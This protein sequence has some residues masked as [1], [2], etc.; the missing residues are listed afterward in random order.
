MKAL[1]PSE[2]HIA[3]QP[4]PQPPSQPAPVL[5]AQ[6]IPG[7]RLSDVPARG[8]FGNVPTAGKPQSTVQPAATEVTTGTATPTTKQHRQG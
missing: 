8:T 4:A 6:G 5:P 3:K 2:G 7:A 1:Q